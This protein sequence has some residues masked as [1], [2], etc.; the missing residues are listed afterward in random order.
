MTEEIEQQKKYSRWGL[1][2]YIIA[3]IGVAI[4]GW[5]V[6]MAS[7]ETE[8][9]KQAVEAQVEL[10]SRALEPV[11]AV[12]GDMII[13]Q[14]SLSAQ[15]MLAGK[16]GNIIGTKLTTYMIESITPE[17]DELFRKYQTEGTLPNPIEWKVRAAGDRDINVRILAESQLYDSP[18]LFRMH[19]VTIR[20]KNKNT[21]RIE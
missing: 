18:G 12:D 21:K 3:G 8:N 19:I 7:E 14:A 13:Q 17:G 5:Q 11:I 20:D 9:H 16:S 4:M 15:Q 10:L 1:V 2:A 6:K